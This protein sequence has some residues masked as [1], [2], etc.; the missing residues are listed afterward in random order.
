MLKLVGV[1]LKLGSILVRVIIVIS[2]FL[3]CPLG[4][5]NPGERLLLELGVWL[6]NHMR[7]GLLL[8]YHLV[9]HHVYDGL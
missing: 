3:W 9:F 1:G 6:M 5:L 7:G 2:L 4:L 8:R